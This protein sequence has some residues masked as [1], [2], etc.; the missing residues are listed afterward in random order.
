M[1]NQLVNT[2]SYSVIDRQHIQQIAAE[3]DTSKSG[4]VSPATEAKLGHMLGANFLIF[5]RV[6]QF[7]KTGGSSGGLGGLGGGLLGAG[8]IKTQKLTLHVSMR[9]IEANTG[10]IVATADDSETKSGTSFALGGAGATGGVG[11]TSSDFTSSIVG[12]LITVVANNLV[13]QLDP[14]K[15]VVAPPGPTINA[16][17]LGK[18]GD[19]VIINAGVDKGVTVGTYFTIYHV[20]AFK[21]PDTGKLLESHVKRGTIQILSVDSATATGKLVDGLASAADAAVSGE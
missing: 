4:D 18:D 6:D 17:V 9:V 10:R 13:K 5:G 19:S 12:Q 15:L 2:G 3:Q 16:K 20:K 21:D 7:D 11:Y 1:T 8:G 14:T